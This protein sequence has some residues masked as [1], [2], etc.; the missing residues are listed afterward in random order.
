MSTFSKND[1]HYMSLALELADQGRDGVKANPMVGCVVVKDDQI[2]AKGYHQTFGEAHAEINALNQINH[3]ADGAILYVTLEPCSHQGKTP[4]C[5]QAIINSGIKQVVIAMLDPNPLVSGQGLSMLEAANIK[6]S[7][8]L[9]E[10][11]ASTLNRGFIKRMK[12]GL[13]FV[14]CK[15]A[16]S[17]DGKTAMASGESQWIT[18]EAARTDVQRLRAENQAI[19][20]GSGTILSDNPS[21]TVR[22][23]NSNASPLR[24]VID[25]Q[26]QVTDQALNIFS[27]DTPTLILNPSN[28]TTLNNDK[29]DL[30][31]AL[32]QLGDQGINTVLLEAGPNLIGAMIETNL[33]NEFIIYTAPTLMGSNANSMATLALDAMTD[34]IQLKFNDIRMVGND[35]RITANIKT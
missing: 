18:G 26:Q 22:L 34:K 9:L 17:L 8:G 3:Q 30:T 19:M 2:I 11:E 12:T 29:I 35:I 14:T 6:V 20:T 5:A 33:I 4:P 25:S 1:S 32:K 24:V 7:V 28:S 27:N 16:M 10:A 21:M 13:P 15:I 31:N 23:D